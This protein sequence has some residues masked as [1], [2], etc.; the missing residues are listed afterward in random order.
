MI[1]TIKKF[2]FN[3]AEHGFMIASF[4]EEGTKNPITIK[5]HFREMKELMS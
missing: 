1:G 4:L 2:F 5:E 3:N